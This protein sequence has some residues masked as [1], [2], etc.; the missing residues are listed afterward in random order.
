MIKRILQNL[1]KKFNNLEIFSNF[2]GN[3]IGQNVDEGVKVYKKSKILKK[4]I[5]YDI[6]DMK[7]TYHSNAMVPVVAYRSRCLFC[8]ST[9]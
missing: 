9:H 4:N 6:Y 5:S 2:S 3:P 8:S 1:K 7:K